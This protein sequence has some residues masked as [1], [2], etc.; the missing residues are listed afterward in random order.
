MSVQET[1]A[2]YEKHAFGYDELRPLSLGGTNNWGNLGMMIL[3]SIDTLYM[4]GLQ[5]QYQRY[6]PPYIP[7]FFPLP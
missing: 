2:V 1:W 5:P 7:P 3:D 6:D 4:M